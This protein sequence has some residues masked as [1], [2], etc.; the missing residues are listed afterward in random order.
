MAL[1]EA[2]QRLQLEKQQLHSSHAENT[3]A[4]EA[5][6]LSL[7][8]CE[9]EIRTREVE[10]ER[11]R[12]EFT[13]AKRLM[14]PQLK[15]ALQDREAASAMR[16]Q[17]EKLLED[18]I[19]KEQQIQD[20]RTSL[21]DQEA[22]AKQTVRECER[23]KKE[24]SVQ[25]DR[26]LDERR[27]VTEALASM[28]DERNKLQKCSVE[29]FRNLHVLHNALMFMRAQGHTPLLAKAKA[30]GKF[31]TLSSMLQSLEKATS[32]MHQLTA[33]MDEPTQ[34]IVI[35]E[36][37][38]ETPEEIMLPPSKPLPPQLYHSSPPHPK[39]VNQE[40]DKACEEFALNRSY[41][42][43]LEQGVREGSVHSV[44]GD[45][46]HLKSFAVKYGIGLI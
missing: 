15:E 37:H 6:Q 24:Y 34:N 31:N 28:K 17:V 11:N 16:K 32:S 44:D 14:D 25:R 26:L 19:L 3:A 45:V 7:K 18:A 38:I 30:P 8:Q 13:I 27:F 12:T 35:N 2:Q 23:L 9:A 42:S 33:V 20:M 29:L 1:A 36:T 40:G 43:V 21:Y 39:E 41:Y 22:K 5:K 46:D 4:I 10:L